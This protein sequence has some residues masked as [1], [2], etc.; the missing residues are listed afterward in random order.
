[1]PVSIDDAASHR[2]DIAVNGTSLGMQ[3]NDPLPLS[4]S[5][6]ERSA[7]VAECVVS[8]EMTRLLQVAQQRGCSIHTGVPML[9]AQLELILAF[10]GAL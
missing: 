2:I 6:I 9:E 10:M 8:P 1:M 5:V 7:L 3:P 4:E